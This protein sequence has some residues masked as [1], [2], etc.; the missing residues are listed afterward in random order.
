MDLVISYIRH[1]D[2]LLDMF[3]FLLTVMLLELHE[4]LRSGNRVEE[5]MN[6]EKV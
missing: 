6:I 5:K 4:I 1:T 3:L 2:S